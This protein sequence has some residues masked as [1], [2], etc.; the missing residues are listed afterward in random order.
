MIDVRRLFRK[1][2][3]PLGKGPDVLDHPDLM[4]MSLREL[5]DLPLPR[6][7]RDGEAAEAAPPGS[8]PDARD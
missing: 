2:E 6:A 4:R 5:A 1:R 8:A 7:W 3:A